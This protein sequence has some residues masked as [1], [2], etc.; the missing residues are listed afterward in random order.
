MADPLTLSLSH[1]SQAIVTRSMIA[2]TVLMM[3]NSPNTVTN[4]VGTSTLPSGYTYVS[5]S[6]GVTHAGGVVTYNLA[7]ISSGN[8]A[9]FN[10][11]VRA[12]NPGNYNTT[13]NVNYKVGVT[14]YSGSVSGS[15]TVYPDLVFTI[16]APSSVARG[17]SFSYTFTVSNPV[18]NPDFTDIKL[19][20]PQS[21]WP[22]ALPMAS[23]TNSPTDPFDSATLTTFFSAQESVLTGGETASAALNMNVPITTPPGNYGNPMTIEYK[24][25]N[26]VYSYTKFLPIV[27]VV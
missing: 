21:G 12:N 16:T 10:F 19:R 15:T 20:N 13:I 7:S 11:N 17:G 18:G 23:V 1:T 6:S 5:G 22:S 14:N 26:L 8:G 25:F 9:F 3:N 2:F 27:Q 4:I 24:A